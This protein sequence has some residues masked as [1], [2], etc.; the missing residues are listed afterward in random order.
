MFR[1]VCSF[2]FKFKNDDDGRILGEASCLLK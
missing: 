1:P 2:S